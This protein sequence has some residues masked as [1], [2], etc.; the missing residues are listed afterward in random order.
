MREY[1][2]AVPFILTVGMER[3]QPNTHA[4]YSGSRS[5]AASGAA[6]AVLISLRPGTPS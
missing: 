6:Q 2:I 3:L 1:P 5:K 4:A